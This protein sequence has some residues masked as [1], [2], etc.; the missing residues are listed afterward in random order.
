[1]T[2]G[3]KGYIESVRQYRLHIANVVMIAYAQ[4][5]IL[6]KTTLCKQVGIKMAGKTSML[7]EHCLFTYGRTQ[8]IVFHMF[9]EF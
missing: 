8:Q 5:I 3:K 2:C 9:Q 1:M 6:C 7:N 4:L